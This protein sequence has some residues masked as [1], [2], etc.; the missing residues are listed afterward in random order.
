[1]QLWLAS[2]A[3]LVVVSSVFATLVFT[4]RLILVVPKDTLL[5]AIGKQGKKS[6]NPLHVNAYFSSQCVLISTI[7]CVPVSSCFLT[8]RLSNRPSS[9]IIFK[10][11]PV[12]PTH[13]L[14]LVILFFVGAFGLIAQVCS[15]VSFFQADADIQV[16]KTLLTM[17]FQ[18]ETAARG[19]LAMFTAV[20]LPHFVRFP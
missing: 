5:R 7:R 3:R 17:G 9:M 12:I 1:V 4:V 15:P 14:G 16:A 20:R 13:V 18:R 2:L 19:S 8:R 6:A 11:S 10:V